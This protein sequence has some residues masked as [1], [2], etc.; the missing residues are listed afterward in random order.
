MDDYI[1]I[2]AYTHFN[3]IANTI[4]KNNINIRFN[5]GDVLD[6]SFLT[7]E[8]TAGNAFR[9]Y[10][11]ESVAYTEIKWPQANNNYLKIVS[12]LTN[13]QKPLANDKCG[14]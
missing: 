1:N 12:A 4:K 3:R 8:A 9:C 7:T 11:D 5:A 6:F 10:Q 2:L 14:I 13:S